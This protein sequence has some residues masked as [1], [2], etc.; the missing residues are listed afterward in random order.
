MFEED[1]FQCV[2]CPSSIPYV[3]GPLGVLLIV[4]RGT[5]IGGKVAVQCREDIKDGGLCPVYAAVGDPA[6]LDENTLC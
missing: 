4:I 6:E 2:S 5:P 3:T 1:V